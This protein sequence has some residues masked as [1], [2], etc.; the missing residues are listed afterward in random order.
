MQKRYLLVSAC[1]GASV[2]LAL[3]GNAALAQNLPVAPMP[4]AAVQAA[5][6]RLEFSGEFIALPSDN[7]LSWNADIKPVYQ[8]GTTMPEK[9][10]VLIRESLTESGAPCDTVVSFIPATRSMVIKEQRGAAVV[11]RPVELHPLHRYMEVFAAV[12]DE[13]RQQNEVAYLTDLQRYGY[14]YST[15]EQLPVYYD[16][17][18]LY[19][20][21]DNEVVYWQVIGNP[22]L[23][24]GRVRL[25]KKLL[26]L[27]NL[28]QTTLTELS[29]DDG[30]KE[31]EAPQAN[32]PA[33]A[34]PPQHDDEAKALAR[35]RYFAQ[36]N[37][38]WVERYSQFML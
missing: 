14:M 12:M 27:D 3:A 22:V 7:R 30:D 25:V 17:A 8:S 33:I 26:Y 1:L 15:A 35:L 28:Q 32:T 13:L 2:W 4:A 38:E 19:F 29:L 21:N 23:H 36:E 9:V 5:P 37:R 6:E 24:Q 31:A 10:S 34:V 18:T 16:R 11:D 20:R